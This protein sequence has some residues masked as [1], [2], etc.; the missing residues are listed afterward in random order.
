[1]L[2]VQP[3]RGIRY[4]PAAG[5]WQSVI[6]PPYDV[7]DEQRRQELAAASPYNI[8]R[9]DIAVDGYDAAAKKWSAWLRDGI[10]ARETRPAMYAY[11]QVYTTSDSKRYVRWGLTA[12][13]KLA[14]YEDG[15]ILPHERTLPHAK[16][17][18][19]ELMRAT[20]TQLSPVFGMHFGATVS[21]DE[22]LSSVCTG[23]PAAEVLDLDGVEHRVWVLDD[24]E[25]LETIQ[26]ALR[27]GK[28]V[29]AD[30]HHRYETA[31]AFRNEQRAK[32]HGN[33]PENA[34]WNYVMMV[35]VDMNSPGL[36]VFPTHRV[37]HSVPG[38]T[39][40]ALLARWQQLLQMTPL[41][42]DVGP[43][44]SADAVARTLI[45]ALGPEGGPP[46]F[47]VFISDGRGFVAVPADEAAWNEQ[48]ADRPAA[49]RGL[50]VAL[51]HTWALP[52][53]ELDE[54]AQASGKYLTFTRSA[55]EA[56]AAVQQGN[57]HAA[58]LVRPTPSEA[59]RD[60]ALAGQSMPQKSTYY[61]PK[62]L[63]GFVMNDLDSPVGL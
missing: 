27:P 62:L 60:V 28:V 13:V 5:S 18:R 49:W 53:L 6:A 16:Q 1:M 55:E 52:A 10:V 61:Y 45:E 24:P 57:A 63:T 12:A 14:A 25:L 17:D 15:V 48:H 39:P 20:R 41:T 40:D 23:E 9:V 29:I 3:F 31:L 26:H 32:R 35:L 47:G 33:W 21:L 22:L 34:A 7:I 2:D 59:V 51:L 37:L 56:I 43:G 58:L 36:T 38:L 11:Q 4:T 30:G 46:R 54:E 44:T 42:A 19:L 50:D 8:V